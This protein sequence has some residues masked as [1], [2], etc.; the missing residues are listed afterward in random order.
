MDGVSRNE[1]I[2]MAREAVVD[3]HNNCPELVSKFGKI[4][5]DQVGVM[6]TYVLPSRVHLATDVPD[7][8]FY[9]FV[10]GFTVENEKPKGLL[11]PYKMYTQTKD[12][13]S[14]DNTEPDPRHENWVLSG[15]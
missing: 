4:T 10:W 8:M 6:A 9:D 2:R 12:K 5:L 7:G 1:L 11:T 13:S 3:Y 14:S 15:F